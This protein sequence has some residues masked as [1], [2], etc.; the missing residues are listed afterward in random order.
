M[1]LPKVPPANNKYVKRRT[2]DKHG[3]TMTDADWV[4]WQ[5]EMK[6]QGV[7]TDLPF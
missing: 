1:N 4:K 5:E 7:N 2:K 3:A 6:A